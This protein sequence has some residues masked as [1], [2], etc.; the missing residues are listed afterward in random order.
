VA[1]VT[2][3][4]SLARWTFKGAVAHCETIDDTPQR[5]GTT[6]PGL[7]SAP[8]Y[9]W[10]VAAAGG[11]EVYQHDLRTAARTT[12]DL[13]PGRHP[14][15]MTFV[16]DPTRLHREDGGWLVGFAHDDARSEA[17]L[18]VLDAAAI[19]NPPVATVAIPRRVPD[20][21][22]GTWIPAT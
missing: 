18:I 7:V 16:R 1:V 4:R 11:T 5:F 22:H 19:A 2:A 20:G 15:A 21:I 17:D 9:L 8:N 6:N 3:A 13:G 14:G 10:T 12:H